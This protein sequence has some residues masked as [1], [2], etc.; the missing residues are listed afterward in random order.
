MTEKLNFFKSRIEFINKSVKIKKS[1][2]NP[3]VRILFDGLKKI[4]KPENINRSL[5][6]LF[7]LL[8]KDNPFINISNKSHIIDNI[9]HIIKKAS[10]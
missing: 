4:A 2:N 6:G 9:T 7:A 3:N 5:Y 1:N 10:Y 8:L